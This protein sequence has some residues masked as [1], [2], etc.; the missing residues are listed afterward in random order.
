MSQVVSSFSPGHRMLLRDTFLNE[1]TV[2]LGISRDAHLLSNAYNAVLE[3]AYR[4]LRTAAVA[5]AA[6]KAQ[7]QQRSMYCTTPS[8]RHQEEA[9]SCVKQAGSEMP[10][11]TR[12]KSCRRLR[13]KLLN[14][15]DSHSRTKS[16]CILP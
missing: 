16:D 4:C 7:K 6:R 13:K 12:Y 14:K 2:R 11:A 9:L 1:R 8:D 10:S 3:E 5:A 15:A